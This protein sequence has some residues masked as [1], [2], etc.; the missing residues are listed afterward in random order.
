[1]KILITGGTGMVGSAFGDIMDERSSYKFVL[2]G[3]NDYDL[4]ITE[5]CSAMI[6]DHRPDAIIHLAARVGGVKG[7]S[8][9]VADF[10]LDN[11]K[12]NTNILDSAHKFRVKKVL[13]L[14]STC[15][16]PDKA[17]YPLT[18]DQIHSGPPHV[19]NFGYAYAKR[20]LDVHSKALR[21]QYGCNFICAIPNNIYGPRDNFDLDCGHVVPA[22]IRKV[23]EAKLNGGEPTFW[24]DGKPLREFTYSRDIA[25]ALI[26]L[27][28]NYEGSE[29]INIGNMEEMSI[30]SAVNKICKKLK[31]DG[32]IIWDTDKP[33]GQFK[34]PSLNNNFIKIGW[35]NSNYTSFNDGINQ[36]C[37]WFLENYPMNIRG[38]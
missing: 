23:W 2:V 14:L 1:M 36:T 38:I 26:F 20:M 4:T 6:S 9:F 18:E 31:Y 25:K 5:E 24:G 28:E 16:Y 21:K 7:N 15:V 17:V 3:S 13:S 35:R 12:M 37:D 30:H 29:P 27:L 10:Y 19:S 22:I 34:K 11:I 8:D 33:S 32:Q